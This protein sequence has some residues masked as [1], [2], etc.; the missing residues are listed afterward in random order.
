VPTKTEK[1]EH[2]TRQNDQATQQA[3]RIQETY[4]PRPCRFRPV[5]CPRER[6][7]EFQ[8]GFR[9]YPLSDRKIILGPSCRVRLGGA[10]IENKAARLNR[11]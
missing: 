1:G 4:S 9:P 6:R 11:P 3:D 8:A 10:G 7:G 5:Q 2:A